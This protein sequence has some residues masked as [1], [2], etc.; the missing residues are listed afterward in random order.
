MKEMIRKAMDLTVREA[1]KS[2]AVAC[3]QICY[4]AFTAIA[5]THN[6]P[7]DFP[8]VEAATGLLSMM[9]SNDGFYKVVAERDG[10]I[11]GSNVLDER[12]PISGVGPI[13]V[14]PR[15]QNREVGRRLM[16]AVMERSES[17]GFPGIRLLQAGYHCRSLALYSKLGFEV[18]EHISCMQGPAIGT[19]VP[20][21]DVRPA[22]EADIAACNDLCVRV[23]GHH[24]GGELRDAIRQGHG[25]VVERNGRV[26]GYTT[27]IAFFGHAVAETNDDLK[28][29]IA[30][31]ASFEGPGFL[32]PSR[33]ADLMRWCFA[34]GLRMTQPFTLMTI[35]LY[36]EP[37]DTYL[38][39]ILY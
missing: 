38:P 16:L 35:G 28:A 26:T 10:S 11:M 15:V 2:D 8:G 22:T 17:R 29:L 37:T 21:C 20:G 24:R 39:S 14:D 5:N 30:A 31:A 3:G 7:P 4:D 13:T 25:A 33:N 6:F 18:R 27:Q 12:N 1:T 32:V 36:N 19:N 34:S 9:F 23:H